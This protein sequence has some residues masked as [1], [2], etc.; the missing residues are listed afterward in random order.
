[1][2]E[3]VFPWAFLLLPL[4]FLVRWLTPAVTHA[5]AAL[6][7]PQA[8]FLRVQ[9]QTKT[10]QRHWRW[11]LPTL[12]WLS[13]LAAIAQPRWVG[14]PI[15]LNPEAREI[16]IALDLSGSMEMDDMTY[17]GRRVT[18]LEAAHSILAE[19]IRRRQGDRIGLIVYADS[20]HVYV[21][22][23]SDLETVAKLAE[24]ARIGLAGQ[25]TAMGDAIALS[26]RY[27]TER[28]STERVV[29]LLTDGMINT[30][31][32]NAE[33]AIHL[34]KNHAIRIHTIG[35]GAEEIRI[36]GLF[37]DRVINPSADLDESFLATITTVTGGL[38]FR[39]RTSEEMEDIY[40]V[41]D[42][43]EPIAGAEHFSRPRTSLAH[44]PVLIALFLVLLKTSFYSANYWQ[45]SIRT[46]RNTAIKKRDKRKQGAQR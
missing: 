40:R 37:G 32:I 13:I 14:E 7:L 1:M 41:I 4:P 38:Y 9:E 43:I 29:L 45:N 16:M 28:E 36:Q 15:A 2:F 30:G 26:I 12:I 20:A 24:E 6:W 21:P 5:R 27:F 25:R 39:A 18:R 17:N 11:L 23:T 8:R 46:G 34:A 33:Q 3:F 22:I 44:I 35:I 42:N 19:F 31:K 10:H